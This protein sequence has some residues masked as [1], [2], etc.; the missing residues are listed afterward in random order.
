MK[1]LKNIIILAAILLGGYYIAL[2]YLLPVD[3]QWLHGT[4]SYAN[5]N[6][7]IVTGKNKDG[8]HFHANGTVDLIDGKSKPYLHCVYTALVDKEVRMQCTVRGKQREMIFIIG[9][10][11][12]SL[13]N[14]DDPDKGA[15][16]KKGT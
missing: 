11:K 13:A 2:K 4:W 14:I 15:Y 7:Q 5:S 12:N 16:I 8:M 10:N 1:A 3:E 6:G 9:Q